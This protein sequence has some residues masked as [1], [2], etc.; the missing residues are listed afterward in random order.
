[1]L[2]AAAAVPAT[3]SVLNAAK[4]RTALF[5]VAAWTIGLPPFFNM[6]FIAYQIKHKSST[7]NFT[8]LILILWT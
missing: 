6:H 1:L 8:E 5:I 3:A 7:E 4:P 2:F